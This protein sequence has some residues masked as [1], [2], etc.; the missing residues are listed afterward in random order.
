MEIEIPSNAIELVKKWEGLH[1]RKSDGLVYPYVCP[2]GYWTIG[3]GST[4]LID[5]SPVTESTGP[6]TEQQCEELMLWELRR[7]VSD[8]IKASPVLAGRPEA[9]GAIASFIFNLGIGR[10]R[11]STLRR[12]V[13]Q[14][15]WEEARRQIKKWVYGGGRRLPGL[16]ARR[17]EE[18]E[19]LVS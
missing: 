7:N 1:K 3:Y 10:Y 6:F 12:V 17:Q 11:A 4:R 13:N 2:A 18:S 19:Y 9:L 8:A 14:E 5:G 16:I 15:N